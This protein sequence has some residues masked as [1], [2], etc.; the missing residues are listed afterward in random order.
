MATVMLSW[1]AIARVAQKWLMREW[2]YMLAAYMA[3]RKRTMRSDFSQEERED[4]ATVKAEELWGSSN[5]EIVA[6]IL[7]AWVDGRVEASAVLRGVLLG[8]DNA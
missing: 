2:R 8:L 3:L 7:G 4:R 6:R 1:A 5:W